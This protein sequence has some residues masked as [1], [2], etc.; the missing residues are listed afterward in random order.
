M[1][2][3]VF[4]NRQTFALQLLA[5]KLCETLQLP[6]VQIHMLPLPF[7]CWQPPIMGQPAGIGLGI[8]DKTPTSVAFMHEFAHHLDNRDIRTSA[9]GDAACARWE[10]VSQDEVNKQAHTR[11]FYEALKKVIV[12]FG[13]RLEDYPWASDYEWIF[14]WAKEE[15]L[16][17]AALAA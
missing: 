1:R 15:G 3:P 11:T 12:A 13:C 10:N 6:P 14:G 16:V 4:T 8:F 7:S 17:N 2:L 9:Q 5:N